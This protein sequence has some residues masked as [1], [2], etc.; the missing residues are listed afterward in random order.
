MNNEYEELL[1]LLAKFLSGDFDQI[2]KDY[3][4]EIGK[5]KLTEEEKKQAFLIHVLEQKSE[6]TDNKDGTYTHTFE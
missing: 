6:V 1:N 2:Y 4:K 3:A 5:D